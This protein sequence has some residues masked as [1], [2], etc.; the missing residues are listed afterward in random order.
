MAAPGYQLS[1]PTYYRE[2]GEDIERIILNLD[3]PSDFKFC[4]AS[5]CDIKTRSFVLDFSDDEA[6]C[7]F[8]L[9]ADELGKLLK[10]SR[11][12]SLNT[13]WINIWRPQ[14]QKE[15]LEALARHYDFSPRLLGLMGSAPL[16]TVRRP[17]TPASKASSS[18]SLFAQL[19][20][21]GSTASR[22][23]PK[24]DSALDSEDSIGLTQIEASYKLKGGLEINQYVLA[25]ELYYYTS[26][27]WGRRCERTY[28]SVCLSLN[29]DQTYAWAT[30]HSTTSATAPILPA[31]TP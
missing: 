21:L 6:W 28:P 15:I 29:D 3:S 18:K 26:M 19:L 20:T 16:C 10:S 9:E 4:E 30:T 22:R 5:L 11:P 24:Y 13:R 1:P 25:N 23:S 2:L 31:P 8:N 27:D 14:E 7:G 12:S 17:H